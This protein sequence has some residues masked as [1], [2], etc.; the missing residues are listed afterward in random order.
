MPTNIVS[1]FEDFDPIVGGT[2]LVLSRK[3]RDG[4]KRVFLTRIMQYKKEGGRTFPKISV[5]IDRKNMYML[6]EIEHDGKT[7]I[8][9]EKFEMNGDDLKNI[10]N[11]GSEWVVINDSKT[12]MGGYS[13]EYRPM[14]FLVKHQENIKGLKTGYPIKFEDGEI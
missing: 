8:W 11:M 3:Y 2:V 9:G 6:K 1:I 12:P 10:M 14:D 5:K 7:E 13:I 4:F